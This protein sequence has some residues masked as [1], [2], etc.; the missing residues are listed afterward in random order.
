MHATVTLR[1]FLLLIAAGSG[2]VIDA[3]AQTHGLRRHVL[4]RVRR[5]LLRGARTTRPLEAA[6]GRRIQVH[7]E[8]SGARARSGVLAYSRRADSL[9]RLFV[10]SPGR[11]RR[12]AH[13]VEGIR[14][15]RADVSAPEDRRPRASQR[16]RHSSSESGTSAGSRRRI[17]KTSAMCSRKRCR[18]Q[19][20]TRERN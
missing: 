9:S 8:R 1:A 14:R 6:R 3:V 16:S 11:R 20:G 18:R 2:A 7:G 19:T 10:R 12:G 5:R 4:E 13:G 17:W 15:H